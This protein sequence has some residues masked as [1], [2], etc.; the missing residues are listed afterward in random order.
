MPSKSP[1]I[2]RAILIPSV[3]AT[4]SSGAASATGE[5][6]KVTSEALTTAAGAVYTLTLTNPRIT[7]NSTVLGTVKYG[8]AT[9]GSPAITR[10][11]PAN[12]SVVVLVQ[13]VHASSALDGTIVLDLL[14]L[15][16]KDTVA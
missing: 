8:T 14:V 7:S 3:S 13:N 2:L 11:T 16:P 12:G 15:N 4:A 5:L 10:I 1:S 9:A 6:V